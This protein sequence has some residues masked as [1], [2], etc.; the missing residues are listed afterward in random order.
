M[1]LVK[2]QCSSDCYASKN[3][4]CKNKMIVMDQNKQC[5]EYI[6]KDVWEEFNDLERLEKSL[7]VNWSQFTSKEQ[8]QS[9][10]PKQ[11]CY[12]C[13]LFRPGETEEGDYCEN[14]HTLLADQEN[15]KDYKLNKTKIR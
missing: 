15:C 10:T 7:N 4:F 8:N 13:E 2:V 5:N 3:G 1:T 9:S 14:G 6:P 12:F 11:E